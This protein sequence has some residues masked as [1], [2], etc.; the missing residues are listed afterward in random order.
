MWLQTYSPN[1]FK[2]WRQG[3]N[4][5]RVVAD[6]FLVSTVIR[7]CLQCLSVLVFSEL[8]APVEQ[9]ISGLDSFQTPKDINSWQVMAYS[10]N[11][12]IQ[13]STDDQGQ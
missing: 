12:D 9:T 7:A 3:L 13:L 11:E 1:D 6:Q 8:V 2:R 10:T 4:L 5:I